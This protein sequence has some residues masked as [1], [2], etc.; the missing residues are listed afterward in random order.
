MIR[1]LS[2][3]AALALA[4]PAQAQDS[5]PAHGVWRGTVGSQPVYACFETGYEGTLQGVYYYERHLMPIRLQ[6]DGADMV[7]STGYEEPTG[8]R[9]HMDSVADGTLSAT[10]R[11]GARRVPVRLQ[12]IDW[13]EPDYNEQACTS[14]AFIAPRFATG[15]WVEET[16]AFDGQAIVTTRF[17]PP[18][19]FVAAAGEFQ[20]VVLAGLRLVETQPGDGAI[21]A[22]LALYTS[23]DNVIECFAGTLS[24]TGTD[25]DLSV[26]ITPE[27]ITD[28]WLSVNIA[29]GDYCGGAHPNYSEDREVFDRQSGMAVQPEE[30]LSDSAVI[31]EWHQGG[32][33]PDDRYRED[34]LTDTI[35]ALLMDRWPVQG[36]PEDEECRDVAFGTYGWDIGLVPGGL[37]FTPVLPHVAQAC[38]LTVRVSWADMA[39]FLNDAGRGAVV[40]L[41]R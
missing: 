2:L 5:D 41:A 9:W 38:A 40:Q 15:R 37:A 18:P 29:R 34:R 4:V 26:T 28:R 19:A 21:N 39:P 27:V 11:Q 8:G 17:A 3:I 35:L 7:E 10:F 12:R 20:P 14:R 1:K 31:T 6:M 30:W 13:Q 22:D 36:Q 25:G 32:G 23:L 33:G 16:G 24:Y